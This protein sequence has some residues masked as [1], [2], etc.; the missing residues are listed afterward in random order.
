MH[1]TCDKTIAMP[2]PFKYVSDEMTKAATSGKRSGLGIQK[3]LW[4]S[5]DLINI[6]VDNYI[7]KSMI[8]M[9]VMQDPRFIELSMSNLQN[10]KRPLNR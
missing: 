1:Q 4:K 7:I 2:K 8:M 3:G 6:Y 9:I 5:H 10:Y